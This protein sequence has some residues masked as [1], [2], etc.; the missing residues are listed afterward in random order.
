[1]YDI[2]QN[3]D[4]AKKLNKGATIVSI[5]PDKLCSIVKWHGGFFRYGYT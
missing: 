4:L 1:M 2:P 5:I 3:L